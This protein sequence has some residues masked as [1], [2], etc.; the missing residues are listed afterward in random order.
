[1]NIVS[2]ARAD[3]CFVF[4]RV[5]SKKVRKCFASTKG[6]SE[7][8]LGFLTFSGMEMVQKDTQ[9]QSKVQ[10]HQPAQLPGGVG[11]PPDD[12][13]GGV[14]SPPGGLAGG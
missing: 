4:A 6:A 12:T 11:S 2:N 13:V 8:N 5:P 10:P 14:S 3:E 9:I 7:E 1:M